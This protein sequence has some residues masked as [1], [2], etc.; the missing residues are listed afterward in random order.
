MEVALEFGMDDGIVVAAVLM[1]RVDG[2]H[3]TIEAKDEIAEIQAHA[4]SVGHGYLAPKG[5]EAELSA[6]LFLVVAQRP[7]ITGID[8]S[9][10]IEF[11]EQMCAPLG[12]EVEL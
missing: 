11:P 3:G 12:A 8:E 2:F 5:V 7:D 9:G 4:Q 1:G 6:R 10:A